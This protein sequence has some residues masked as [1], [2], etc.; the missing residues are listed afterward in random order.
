MLVYAFQ[1][2]LSF[3]VDSSKNNDNPRVLVHF[4]YKQLLEVEQEAVTTE[5]TVRLLS[6]MGVLGAWSPG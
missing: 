4:F 5:G 3:L 1:V 2:K 6:T